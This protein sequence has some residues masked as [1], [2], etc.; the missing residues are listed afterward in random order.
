M[1]TNPI[2]IIPARMSSA[3]LPEKVLADLGGK[4]MVVRVWEQGIAAN[5]GPVVVACDDIRVAQVIEDVGG[6]VCMTPADLPSGSDRVYNALERIDPQGKH[7]IVINL[8]G[9]SPTTEPLAVQ[10]ALN[11]LQETDFDISTLA[12]KNT[13][14]QG[15]LDPSISKIALKGPED[16]RVRQAVYFS[17]SVIPHGAETFFYHIGLYAYRRQALQRFVQSSPSYLESCEKLEQLRAL[18][19]N[20]RIGVALVDIILNFTE[21]DAMASNFDLSIAATPKLQG[22]IICV[23]NKIAAVIDALVPF[24]W[25]HPWYVIS[26]RSSIA[27]CVM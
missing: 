20:L 13:N 21:L 9:D 6:R 2:I 10:M 16:A 15:I 18:E 19:L 23:P 1:S 22:S 5:V 14:Y 17:R 7:D 12:V 3:R 11:A 27:R 25:R 24:L 8:Q 4:P 26:E